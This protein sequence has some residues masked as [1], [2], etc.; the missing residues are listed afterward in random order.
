[1]NIFARIVTDDQRFYRMLSLELSSCGIALLNDADEVPDGEIFSIVDLDF[2]GDDISE[3][4]ADSRVIGFS[5]FCKDELVSTDECFAFLHRPFL[6]SE[7]FSLIF[8]SE[9]VSLD[10]KQA[11]GKRSGRIA[12]IS[13]KLHLTVDIDEKKAILG[14]EKIN[15][16]DTEYNILAHLCKKRGET[17][18]REELAALLGSCD[19]NNVDVYICMLRR[20]IDNKFGMKFIYTIRGKGYA[21]K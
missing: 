10:A 21:L 4:S 12:A 11:M 19:G 8:S 2:Y 18:S 14:N 7:L 15:L 16:T 13:R 9:D 3:F 17:V 20:K 6:M 5:R 1:M